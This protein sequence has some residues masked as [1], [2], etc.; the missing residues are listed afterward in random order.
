MT[1]HYGGRVVQPAVSQSSLALS[2]CPER[3]IRGSLTIGDEKYFVKPSAYFLDAEF[4]RHGV[5]QA[6]DE[7][8]INKVS[9]LDTQGLPHSHGIERGHFEQSVKS[10]IEGKLNI[11][12]RNSSLSAVELPGQ[13]R[14]RLADQQVELYIIMDPSMADAFKLS[15]DGTWYAQM[16]NWIYDIIN[17]VNE[18]YL[19][20]DTQ[21]PDTAIGS[22][23]V[24]LVRLEVIEVWSG[25]Y[26]SLQPADWKNELVDSNAY[27]EQLLRWVEDN[28]RNAYDAIHL[29][30]RKSVSDGAGSQIWGWT[31]QGCLCTK[32]CAATDWTHYLDVW[33]VY[34]IA[35]ML[36]WNFGAAQD[37]TNNDCGPG[38]GMMSNPMNEL[39]HGWSACTRDSWLEYYNNNNQLTCLRSNTRDFELDYD[40]SDSFIDCY[41]LSGFPEKTMN[42]RWYRQSGY[43]SAM[44]IY[45]QRSGAYFFFFSENG[46]WVVDDELQSISMTDAYCGKTAISGDASGCVAG[47]WRVLNDNRNGWINAT[48]ATVSI[49]DEGQAFISLD[50]TCLDDSSYAELLCLSSALL[51]NATMEFEM[52][53]DECFEG[54]PL[55]VSADESYH[56]H[57]SPYLKDEGDEELSARW[58]ISEGAV[59]NNGSAYCYREDLSDCVTG[60]WQVLASDADSL[61]YVTD[62]LMGYAECADYI[63]SD[64]MFWTKFRRNLIS[65]LVSVL[66]VIAVIL[67]HSLI[68]F[69]ST[70]QDKI[71]VA[72]E[73]D[74]EIEE[75]EIEVEI[76]IEM[77]T[78][79]ITTR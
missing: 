57:Y 74:E 49:C 4:D 65:V 72:C 66:V 55:Y 21:Y 53:T 22:I 26:K 16:A 27:W 47:K 17:G 46:Y 38:E 43:Y 3:G 48:D 29:L 68:R 24:R 37:G 42:G 33:T 1:C 73:E 13:N 5:H 7:H 64:G 2:N 28:N 59:Q 69:W 50:T 19:Y 41:E 40:G 75:D 32:T 56:L 6:T 45:T 71:E 31:E 63:H 51:W 52:S 36:G 78:E 14:R 35:R 10:Q 67:V 23:E 76:E 62:E 15:Y 77:E 79:N 70:A 9:D 54:Q 61:E 58:V 18:E 39:V 25:I 30:T 34:N 20:Y 8:L 44:P 60:E 11:P 12:S